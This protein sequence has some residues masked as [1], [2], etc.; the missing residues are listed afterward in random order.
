VGDE[1]I[2]QVALLPEDLLDTIGGRKVVVLVD[3]DVSNTPLSRQEVLDIIRNQMHSYLD[4]GDC[5]NLLYSNLTIRRFSDQWV[6]ASATNIDSAFATME[7]LLSGYSNLPSLL[8]GGLEFTQSQPDP[9]QVVL[10]ADADQYDKLTLANTVINDI[11][12]LMEN[13]VPIHIADYQSIDVTHY[14]FNQYYYTGNGYFYTNLSKMTGGSL[15]RALDGLSVSEAIGRSFK[16]AGGT[17]QAFDLHTSV[18]NGFSHGRQLLND[19]SEMVFLDE[20]IMQTGKFRGEFPLTLEL[21]GICNDRVFSTRYTI[22]E[23]DAIEGDSI[24][25][26]TWTGGYVRSLESAGQTNEVINQIIFSSL[27]E[28]VLSRYTA[29]LCLEP[30]MSYD[31]DEVEDPEVPV[32]VE[33]FEVDS[34]TLRVYP[35]PFHDRLTIELQSDRPGEIEEL[36]VYTLTGALVYRFETGEPEPGVRQVFT[37][38]G[39]SIGGQPVKAGVYL[40]V[41]RTQQLTKTIKLIK[42]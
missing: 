33:E 9:G 34:D 11:L 35:N 28:R 40:L 39:Q 41:Y 37:W 30:D 8:A 23:E 26:E 15:H 38:E 20:A 4:E 27:T 42:N 32:D 21:S 14:Y 29:F 31:P 17:I 2:Y 22:S 16:S 1:G 7:G 10:V 19:R 12:G 24:C 5:F 36:S 13:R 25:V 3:Y 6:P 18:T